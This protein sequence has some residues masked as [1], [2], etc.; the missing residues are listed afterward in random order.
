MFPML[1]VPSRAMILQLANNERLQ[2]AIPDVG[3]SLS[4]VLFK[5]STMYWIY[6]N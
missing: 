2:Y 5:G 3:M 1:Y 6:L 4:H